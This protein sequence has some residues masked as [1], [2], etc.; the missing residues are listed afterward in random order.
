[1]AIVVIPELGDDLPDL[2][3]VAEDATVDDLL[4]QRPV[5]ALDHAVGLGF[6][7]KSETPADT[8]ERDLLQE[9]VGGVLRMRSLS[10]SPALAPA[11]PNSARSPCSMGCK[12]AKR[13][14][15]F[16]AWMP[17]QQASK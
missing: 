4:L 9:I 10:P 16:A 15:V 11:A 13:L 8:P 2:F 6:G 12:A 5:E 7:N 1:V 17:T 3:E 14:P